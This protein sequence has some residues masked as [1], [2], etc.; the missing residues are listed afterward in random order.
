[1]ALG[2]QLVS[3]F[4]FYKIVRMVKY[5]LTRRAP[6]KNVPSNVSKAKSSWTGKKRNIVCEQEVEVLPLVQ[7]VYA[8]N[9]RPKISFVSQR[10]EMT[11]V[12]AFAFSNNEKQR[13]NWFQVKLQFNG[14]TMSLSLSSLLARAPD[15]SMRFTPLFAGP[16]FGSL[17]SMR[18]LQL[19]YISDLHSLSSTPHACHSSCAC[20]HAPSLSAISL[21]NKSVDHSLHCLVAP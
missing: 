8:D 6:S 5:K 12:K 10:N 15:D 19:C 18:R 14:E 17:R 7:I 4:W 13:S 2:L 9:E 3:A 20:P 16:P 11:K 21:S 1:M